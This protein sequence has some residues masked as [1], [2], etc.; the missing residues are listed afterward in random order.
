MKK[1]NKELK[2]ILKETNLISDDME[3]QEISEYTNIWELSQSAKELEMINTKEDWLKVRRR[4][5]MKPISKRIP[6]RKYALRIAAV[7]V[8]AVGLAV[9]LKQITKLFTSETDI[10]ELYA[11]DSLKNIVLPDNS[12]VTL[13]KKSTLAYLKTFGEKNRELK[14]EGEA[15]FS[16][17]HDAARPFIIN[18]GDAVIQ[19][20]GTRF[21]VKCDSNAIIV[22][23]IEGKVEFYD[24]YNKSRKIILQKN[25]TGKFLIKNQQLI[26]I[27]SVDPNIFTWANIFYFDRTPFTDALEIIARHYDKEL[28]IRKEIEETI[29]GPYSGNSL[30]SIIENVQMTLPED[31]KIII[32]ENEII[33]NN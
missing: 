31:V 30:N 15:F 14:L 19:V 11:E 29:N 7:V 4:I 21:N 24:F 3:K 8:L 2:D 1:K 17:A 25:Q 32:T 6:F 5:T 23:V 33:V 13:N 22:S 18:A 9:G 28:I 26:K 16:V 12:E 20:L 27:N 10:T